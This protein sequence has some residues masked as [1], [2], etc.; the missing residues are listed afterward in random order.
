MKKKAFFI[1]L[2]LITGL[3][4]LSCTTT[5]SII[6]DESV[7]PEQSSWVGTDNA[8]VIVGYNGIAVNW[9]ARMGKTIQI[10]AGNTLLEWDIEGGNPLGNT[11][12][13]AKGALFLYNFQP[14]KKY[15]FIPTRLDDK[16][17][18]HVYSYDADQKLPMNMYKEEYHE[19]FH[20]FLYD[21]DQSK[22]VLD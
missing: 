9:K 7:A 16:Y 15:Y 12:Y 20:K 22:T 2:V 11:I 21:E 3:F 10:P 8:G 6:H 17:G 13:K 4:I 18:F 5:T 1:G 19:G 14:Q